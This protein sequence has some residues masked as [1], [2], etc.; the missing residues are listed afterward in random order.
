MKLVGDSPV[1]HQANHLIHHI[2]A[3]RHY[4]TDVFRAFQHL[5]GGIHKKFGAFLHRNSTQKGNHLFLHARNAVDGFNFRAE[6]IH[7]VVYGGNFPLRLVVVFDNGFA[8][9]VAYTDDMVAMVHSV[10]FDSVNRGIWFSAAAVELGGVH[11]DNQ[12]F[13]ADAFGVQAGRVGE[14]VVRMDDVVLIRSGNNAGYDG[15]VIG[16]FENITRITARKF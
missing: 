13:S 7:G 8:R 10:F 11:V 12:R 1:G 9:E 15:I 14:P 6:R 2:A 5:C 4:K 16:F 3:A